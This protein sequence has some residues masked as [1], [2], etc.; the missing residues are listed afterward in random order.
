MVT[1]ECALNVFSAAI[2]IDHHCN[3]TAEGGVRCQ[4]RT[5]PEVTIGHY[6][7][8]R[9]LN[10]YA[11]GTLS[12]DIVYS[13]FRDKCGHPL[14]AGEVIGNPRASFQWIIPQSSLLTTLR[15]MKKEEQDI[16]DIESYAQ[17]PNASKRQRLPD[18]K[19][20]MHWKS[21]LLTLTAKEQYK[22]KS[23]LIEVYAN[24]SLQPK[25]GETTRQYIQRHGQRLKK[26][27]NKKHQGAYS[28]D[29]LKSAKKE[30]E[31]KNNAAKWKTDSTAI[32]P[33]LTDREEFMRKYD[34]VMEDVELDEDADLAEIFGEMSKVDEVTFDMNEMSVMKDSTTR[35]AEPRQLGDWLTIT[36]DAESKKITCD[37]EQCNRYGICTW[38]ATMMVIQF[39]T[40]V[41]A[42][43][44]LVDEG[45]GWNAKVMR[46]RKIMRDCNI[47]C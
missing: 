11:G 34:E 25:P 29:N 32:K 14:T 7:I 22:L 3:Y 28:S 1:K 46:A 38:V 2:A 45:F 37:C 35:I 31:E 26:R 39:N 16:L 27:V 41:A 6:D 47:N 18:D 8:I 33:V 20:T 5:E 19:S 15:N 43:C 17:L 44:K 40:P 10:N 30:N 42:Y 4:F 23:Y 12:S 13:F 24:H 21:V 9:K 36:V